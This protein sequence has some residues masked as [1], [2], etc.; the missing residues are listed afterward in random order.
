MDLRIT[1]AH[2][3]GD[4]AKELRRQGEAGKGLRRELYKGIQRSTKPLKADAKAS[5]AANLPHGGGL[6]DLVAASKLSTR[7]RGGGKN[8]GV[9]IVATGKKVHDA[10][11]TDR[12]RLRHPTFGRPRSWVTQQIEP[13]WFTKPMEAGAGKVRRE[14]LQAMERVARAIV[15]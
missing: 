9:R 6:A 4:L 7:T 5:A 3:L 13:G 10:A 11:A 14:L 12:G 1:G 8:V 2:Q 15:R